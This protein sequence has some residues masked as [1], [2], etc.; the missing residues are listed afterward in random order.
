MLDINGAWGSWSDYGE[1]SREC[2]GKTAHNPVNF[3]LPGGFMTRTRSCDSPPPSCGGVSCS[4]EKSQD[5][6]C[7][8]HCCGKTQI[9]RNWMNSVLGVDGEWSPWSEEGGCSATCGG[10]RQRSTRTCNSP[11]PSCGGATCPGS[12]SQDTNCN[13]Q[14]CGSHH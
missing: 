8:L 1:C 13:T 14:C 5:K 10:G 3:S 4:G 7:N 11:A 9:S 2:G 12:S 6:R